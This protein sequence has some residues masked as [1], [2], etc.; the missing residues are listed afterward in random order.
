M[1]HDK[2]HVVKHLIVS[3][4]LYVQNISSWPPILQFLKHTYSENLRVY[5]TFTEV[6]P[7][8]PRQSNKPQRPKLW[9][10]S[11]TL[12]DVLMHSTTIWVVFKYKGDINKPSGKTSHTISGTKNLSSDNIHTTVR[13][14]TIMK[15]SPQTAFLQSE[16]WTDFEKIV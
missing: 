1:F 2:H 7:L 14:D 5:H 16:D 13:H 11:A 6:L 8:L 3:H 10:F 9:G 4:I 12:R 15:K